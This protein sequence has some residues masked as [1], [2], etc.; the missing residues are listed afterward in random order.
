MPHCAENHQWQQ[1]WRQETRRQMDNWKKV[2]GISF[3]GMSAFENK[4]DI[5]LF[6]DFFSLDDFFHSQFHSCFTI[7]IVVSYFVL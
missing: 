5:Y 4:T 2:T 6:L 1:A 7:C 3:H